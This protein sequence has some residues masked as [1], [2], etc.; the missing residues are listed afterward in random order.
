MASPPPPAASCICSTRASRRSPC[1]GLYAERLGATSIASLAGMGRRMPWTSVAFTV[2]AL[3]MIGLPPLA[4]FV[5]KWTLAQGA[6]AAD[7]PWVVGVLIL[8]AGLNAA[9][10]LPVV[11]RIWVPVDEP[12]AGTVP[13]PRPFQLMLWPAVTTAVRA[14]AA[15]V[16]AGMPFA[17][18]DFAG[19]I[20]ERS[21]P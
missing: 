2:G 3:G 18:L 20:A 13:R 11:Y 21:Y 5:S 7:R 12:A 10:F 19:L 8:S 14:V 6:L 16:C 9:Y 15:G 4:G 17:P 1:A